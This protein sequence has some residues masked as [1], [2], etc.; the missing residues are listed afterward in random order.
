MRAARSM[1]W[2][3]CTAIFPTCVMILIWGLVAGNYLMHMLLRATLWRPSV[4]I[5]GH[6]LLA[7]QI[8]S[9]VQVTRT[10]PGSPPAGWSTEDATA[11]SVFDEQGRRVE[12]VREKP[13]PR[14]VYVRRLGETV[15]GFDHFC[16]WI[17]V[18]IGWLNRKFFILFV[19]WSAALSGFG[20]ALAVIDMNRLVP[21]PT[22]LHMMEEVMVKA[23]MPMPMPTLPFI[24]LSLAMSELSTPEL[25][26]ACCLLVCAAANMVATLLLGI[27]GGWHVQMALRNRTS[28]A[29][30]ENEEVYDVGSLSNWRQVMGRKW[31]LWAL[32]VWLGDAPHGDGTAW[33]RR[34]RAS[35]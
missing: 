6:A 31:W 9:F 11:T 22:N 8:A 33:P 2:G 10:H 16:W 19:L 15:L 12:G 3:A 1:P 28:I 32:P 27:F 13:P 26:H 23:A 14:A 24:L 35:A 21:S 29:E 18:P 20:F 5:A 34:D 4:I 30:P 25:V 7:L 17:G